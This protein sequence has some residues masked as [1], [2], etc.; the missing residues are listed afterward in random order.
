MLLRSE[1]GQLLGGKYRVGDV[2]FDGR[3]GHL[4]VDHFYSFDQFL[5]VWSVLYFSGRKYDEGFLMV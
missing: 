1:F 5:V 3:I 2:D 4:Y